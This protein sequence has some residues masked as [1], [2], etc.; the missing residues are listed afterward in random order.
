MSGDANPRPAEQP[1]QYHDLQGDTA[2]HACFIMSSAMQE[3]MTHW[4]AKAAWRWRHRAGGF[5][6]D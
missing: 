4:K 5:L 6:L 3:L 2:M 1:W